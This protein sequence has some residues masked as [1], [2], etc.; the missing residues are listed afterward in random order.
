M[1][2]LSVAGC[3]FPVT[4]NIIKNAGYIKRFMKRAKDTGADLLLTSKPACQA[5]PA[6]T[7]PPSKVT[8]GIYSALK[9]ISCAYWHRTW[10]FG[11]FWV[12]PIFATGNTRPTNCLYII[13]NRGEVKDRYDKCMC[14]V[15]GVIRKAI[16]PDSDW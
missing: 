10:R 5:M 2:K 8:I 7:F 3:Q 16:P 13:N 14:S 4:E 15:P 11:S 12:H 9:R 6:S 1:K